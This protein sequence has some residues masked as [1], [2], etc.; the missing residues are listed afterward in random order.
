MKHLLPICAF[1]LL[2]SCASEVARAPEA[3]IALTE[4]FSNER[5]EEAYEETTASSSFALFDY[6]WE[7][8]DDL[9]LNNLIEEALRNS[10]DI[11]QARARLEQAAATARRE[12]SDLLPTATADLERDAN[13]GNTSASEDSEFTLSGAASYE[14]DLWGKNRADFKSRDLEASAAAANI[15]SAAI[16]LS[17][18]IAENYIR[19]AS[20]REEE[21]LLN[22][23]IE[24]NNL[25]TDL[26]FKRFAGGAAGSLD[27]LQ[28]QEVL[29][30]RK[31][32]LPN[33]KSGQ[34]LILTQLAVLS[35]Q[36][37][38]APPN[39][40]VNKLPELPLLPGAGVPSDL[41]ADRP[42]IAAS[43]ETLRAAD[44]AAESAFADR[45]PSF[46]IGINYTSSASKLVD[47]TESWLLNLAGSIAQP[48]FDGSRRRF[49]E[50]R[51]RALADERF[52]DYR[53]TLLTAIGEVEDALTQNF[54]QAQRITAVRDQL[55]ASRNSFEQ[56]QISYGG[57]DTEYIS[58][59]NALL[60]TQ[61]LEQQ[62]VRERRDLILNRIALYRALGYNPLSK[63]GA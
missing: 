43:W 55:D 34:A 12:F 62:L 33:L 19:L 48:I 31:A 2:C 56:A 13:R 21:A 47:L 59:L 1:L 53:E 44:W 14:L 45:L 32:D 27:V 10:P 36:N 50:R 26:Q 6:W 40:K 3:G 29:A 37:P 5:Y 25:L 28:Q 20:L 9:E 42:D 35:G 58:V 11:L 54:Y 22:E 52:Q 8:F 4:N 41:L 60:N 51:T 23:Q 49:E 17:A 57:G 7:E 18:S 63:E 16:T 39:L 24:I 38:S 30:S 46:D 15:Q 61:N